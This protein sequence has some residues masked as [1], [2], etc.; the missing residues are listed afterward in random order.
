VNK[1]SGSETGLPYRFIGYGMS[2]M[3]KKAWPAC[4]VHITSGNN[5]YLKDLINIDL[6]NQYN[7][8]VGNVS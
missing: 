6:E 3:A 4:V 1:T 7:E 2:R 8:Y 5:D